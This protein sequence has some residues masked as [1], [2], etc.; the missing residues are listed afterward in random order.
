M[1]LLLEI[2]G[3]R[4]AKSDIFESSEVPETS[5]PCRMPGEIQYERKACPQTKD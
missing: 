2:K 4:I 3:K 1:N 5:S